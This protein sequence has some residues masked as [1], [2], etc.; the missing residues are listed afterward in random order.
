M[1]T[2]VLLGLVLALVALSGARAAGASPPD[3]AMAL[4]AAGAGVV[5]VYVA[6]LAISGYLLWRRGAA[7]AD[8][9]RLFRR[10][11]LLGKMYRL[12]AVVAYAVILFGFR[13]PAL[14]MA[15][16]GAGELPPT[17]IT[18]APLVAIFLA[19]WAAL[20]VAD[21]QLRARMAAR[22][23]VTVAVP[24]TLPRYIAFM[25]RQY[26]L[27]FLL[28]VL[29]MAGVWDVVTRW[30]GSPEEVPAAQAILAASVLAAF[31]LAGPWVRVCWR[32]RPL[33][34]GDLRR[35]LVALA[36][37]AGI[38]IGNILVWVWRSKFAFRRHGNVGWVYA[39]GERMLGVASALEACFAQA[40]GRADRTVETSA[41]DRARS[42]GSAP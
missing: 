35:R 24:W 40:D 27:I 42:G 23:A 32:T 18:L 19:A 38:R 33:P 34:D 30:I 16:G 20:Y 29:A 39:H 31:L 22:A 7:A 10:V 9:R 4:L 14:A 17:A 12:L 36:D 26:L 3:P 6:G 41:N 37:R 8:E 21:R 25:A 28:P 13:W 2:Y 1:Y 11:G 5:A 15:W